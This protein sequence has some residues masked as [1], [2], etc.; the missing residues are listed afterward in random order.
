MAY[1]ALSTN[2]QKEA[3][4]AITAYLD[5]DSFSTKA[6]TLALDAPITPH[7][8]PYRDLAT[9]CLAAARASLLDGE[10]V[11]AIRYAEKGFEFAMKEHV[12]KCRAYWLVGLG[13]ACRGVEVFDPETRRIYQ[14]KSLDT[15]TAAVTEDPEAWEVRFSL[16]I[17]YRD[18]REVNAY[19]FLDAIGIV[20]DA[21]PYRISEL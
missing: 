20:T 3:F 13:Y 5:R 21:S 1:N 6:T 8:Q 19:M 16:A 10:T 15:L 11:Q 17:L 18:S 12:M 2:N 4:L 7:A 14:G 9:V